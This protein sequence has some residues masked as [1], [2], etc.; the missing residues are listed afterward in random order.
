M[1]IKVERDKKAVCKLML[2]SQHPG[3]YEIAYLKTLPAFRGQGLAR[4]ALERVEAL[5]D[6]RGWKLIGVADPAKD[7]ALE[8]KRFSAWLKRRGYVASWFQFRKAK[9]LKP[10]RVWIR[11]P[12]R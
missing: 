10:K 6:R 3:Y 1:I 11:H 4:Q 7:G 5:A 8:A 2:R 9:D 12:K